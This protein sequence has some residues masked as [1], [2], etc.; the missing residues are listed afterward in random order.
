[1]FTLLTPNLIDSFE[2]ELFNN[3]QKETYDS[4]RNIT[5]RESS[6]LIAY[7]MAGYKKKDIEVDI[8][9]NYLIIQASRDHDILG[10][11]Q[12]YKKIKLG[13]L[14]DLEKIEVSLKDGV[15][16]VDLPKIEKEVRKIEIK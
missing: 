7:E 10:S 8:K 11:S 16:M 9:E 6:Y 13:S 14:V 12:F 1:M 2:K 15:L 3:F 4:T 5:E